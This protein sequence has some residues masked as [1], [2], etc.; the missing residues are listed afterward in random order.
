MSGQG[1]LAI[2]PARSGSKSLLDKNIRMIAG[3]PLLAW[4]IEHAL[5][6]RHITRIVVSTDSERYARL[7]ASTVPKHPSVVWTS[8]GASGRSSST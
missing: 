6:C 3:K 4:S 1:V 8:S 7:R 2:I 5:A